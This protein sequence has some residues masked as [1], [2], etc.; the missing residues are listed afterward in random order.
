MRNTLRA[1]LVAAAL[2]AGMG[3]APDTASA[4]PV[5]PNALAATTSSPASWVCEGVPYPGTK[6][7]FQQNSP[8]HVLPIG[9]SKIAFRTGG[10][11]TVTAE[12]VNYDYGTTW[13]E[14]QGGYYIYE[15]YRG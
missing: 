9:S 6:V 7:Y 11:Q 15:G 3:A 5:P 13:W 14:I 4:V 1:L 8:A 2:A 10:W 12:C